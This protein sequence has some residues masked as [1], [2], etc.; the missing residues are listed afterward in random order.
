MKCP[1]CGEDLPLGVEN[2]ML[3]DQF[4]VKCRNSK[5]AH[6]FKIKFDRKKVI[7]DAIDRETGISHR[8]RP[9]RDNDGNKR[10]PS[11]T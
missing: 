9:V 3:F 6:K 2:L 5:C 11:N 4:E 10:K 8:L 7:V 1:V